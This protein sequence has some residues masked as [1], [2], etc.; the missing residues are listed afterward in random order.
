MTSCTASLVFLPRHF[1]D[2]LLCFHRGPR[3][4]RGPLAFTEG[5][6]ATFWHIYAHKLLS[7]AQQSWEGGALIAPILQMGKP[8]LVGEESRMRARL[9]AQAVGAAA[10]SWCWASQ[11]PTYRPR[12][13]QLAVAGEEPHLGLSGAKV[14]ALRESS[15]AL[16]PLLVPMTLTPAC[17]G[18][19]DFQDSWLPQSASECRRQKPH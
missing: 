6:P 15:L 2:C 5:C 4:D 7:A 13:T 16:Q 1:P 8:R 12:G 3:R 18:S 14:G 17:R 19:S 11:S 10:S 9:L